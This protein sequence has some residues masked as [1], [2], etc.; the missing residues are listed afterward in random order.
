MLVAVPSSIAYGIA[1]YTVL[2]ASY[3][4]QGAI[5]G[6]LGAIVMGIVAPLT[7]GAPRLI[8]APCAPAVPIM[9]A[10]GAALVA[11]QRSGVGPLSPSQVL[12]LWPLA[13]LLTG[14]LQLL[15]GALGGGRLI[16]YIPF[17]VASGY[18]SGVGVLMVLDQAPK[19]LGLPRGT[20]LWAGI[21]APGSWAWPGVV[22]GLVTIGVMLGAPRLTKALPPSILGVLAGV[23]TY[24][25]WGAFAPG[26]LHFEHNRLIIG[27]V[28]GGVGAVVG[29]V[30]EQ[31]R[32]LGGL[33]WAE[34]EVVLVP[35]VTLSVLLSIDTLKTVVVI[36]TLG[37]SRHDSD[38]ELRAQ[39]CANLAAALVGGVPGSAPLG[40]ALINVNSG[41]RTNWSGLFEGFLALGT[42]VLLG[43][44][45]GW[46]PIATLAGILI[47]V[48]CR[49]VD[50]GSVQLVR[51]RSTVL[52]FGVS[53]MVVVVAV[54]WGLV[55]ATG[56]GLGLAVLLFIRE[57]MRGSVIRRK[58]YGHQLSSKR[59]RLPP[60]REVLRRDGPR[61]CVCEL[62]GNLFF[63]TTDRLFTELESDLQQCRHLLLDLRRVQS[64]DYTAAHLLEQ[65][66]ALLTARQAYLVFAQLPN[67]LPTGR[68]LAAYFSQLGLVNPTR[69]VRLFDSMDEAL[70]WAE[71]QLLAAAGVAEAG[72]E[73]PLELTHFD[74]LR[75]F[76]SDHTLAALRS[77]L[78]EQTFAANQ[79]IYRAGDHGDE[80]YL[81][82][83]GLVRIL[84]PAA[85]GRHLLIATFGP[86]AFF[87]DM[88][89]LDARVRSADAVALTA[90]DLLVLSR[91]AFNQLSIA[92]PVLG[93]K[94]FARLARA[95][96]IRLRDTDEELRWLQES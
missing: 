28:A 95:L 80:L 24:F 57:Q 47:V 54:G 21:A 62:H 61:T 31:W 75:E 64:V 34:L 66:E 94:M 56:V 43:S 20:P 2:G 36:D 77:C 32:A 38:R 51:Q 45:I 44:L 1:I 35:A 52:D 41:G 9:A 49:M 12:V 5:A 79:T 91:A 86:G 26:L 63:G 6:L 69:N 67:H 70:E 27:Q 7:G 55:I 14:A 23:A 68:D 18:S 39:G 50:W 60:E 81:I 93:A 25:A 10:L 59:H 11:G 37:R 72:A 29:S 84:L 46:V 19:L 40:P 73:A 58:V 48:A 92:H 33:R 65:F 17:P 74:L 90:T 8:S 30:G 16:K 15:Y 82:R 89:F 85:P 83:R 87:G 13:T 71:D 3:V 42:L 88:A 4:G 76:D 53:L 96:A 78:R 22:V